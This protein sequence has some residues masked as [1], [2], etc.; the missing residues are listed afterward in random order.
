VEG[1][2]GRTVGRGR[3]ECETGAVPVAGA[4]GR[5]EEQTSRYQWQVRVAVGKSELVRYQWLV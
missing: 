1:G 3:G 5:W 4:G 2:D